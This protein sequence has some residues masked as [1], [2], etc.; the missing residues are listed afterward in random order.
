MFVDQIHPDIAAV[1]RHSPTSHQ[2][3]ILVA[4]TAFSYPN[5]NAGPT[6]IRPLCFEG[7]LDEIILEAELTHK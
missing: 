5:S 1:T 6:A 7:S 4:H 2:S 3:V